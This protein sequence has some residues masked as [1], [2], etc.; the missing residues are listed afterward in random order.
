MAPWN[1]IKYNILKASCEKALKIISFLRENLD[2][3]FKNTPKQTGLKFL[4][5]PWFCS[6][7]GTH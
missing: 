2:M 1:N 4:L 6:T 7:Q 3:D 5:M